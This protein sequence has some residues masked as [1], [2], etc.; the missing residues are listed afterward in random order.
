MST[1]VDIF[2]QQFIGNLVLL[3]NVVVHRCACECRAKQESEEPRTRVILA[4]APKNQTALGAVRMS[5]MEL[6]V[7]PRVE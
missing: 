6:A 2:C 4:L 7:T 5:S 1:Y 3:E